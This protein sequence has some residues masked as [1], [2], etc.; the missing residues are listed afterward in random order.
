[1]KWFDSILLWSL[2]LQVWSCPYTL[3]D[4]NRLYSNNHPIL[5][6][7]FVL[8]WLIYLYLTLWIVFFFMASRWLNL[9]R[10]L[11]RRSL[12]W[13][14]WRFWIFGICPFFWLWIECYRLCLTLLF[15]RCIDFFVHP[16]LRLPRF[17]RRIWTTWAVVDNF[18][19]LGNQKVHLRLV[20]H[21]FWP[22]LSSLSINPKVESSISRLYTHH[23]QISSSRQGS[24]EDRDLDSTWFFPYWRSNGKMST[25]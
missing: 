3:S 6:L 2:L 14:W 18:C 19:I 5:F 1:M 13:K 23:P 15:W 8:L 12:H 7:V 24:K 16:E 17:Y 10:L 20:W 11:M 4:S 9:F 25:I 21:T 22:I